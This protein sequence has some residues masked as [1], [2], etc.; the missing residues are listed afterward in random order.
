MKLERNIMSNNSG[1]RKD[2]MYSFFRNPT[3]S[4]FF[5]LSFFFYFWITFFFHNSFFHCF[6]EGSHRSHSQGENGIFFWTLFGLVA[7]KKEKA[8]RPKIFGLFCRVNN[9]ITS[10]EKN[11]SDTFFC[12]F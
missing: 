10:K 3:S 2:C 5:L 1:N 11:H 9:L 12:N 6:F 4:Y 8:R 7:F